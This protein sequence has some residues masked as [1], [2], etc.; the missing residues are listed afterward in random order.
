MTLHPHSAQAPAPQ[1]PQSPQD[2]RNHSFAIRRRGYD[3]EEVDAYLD[4]LSHQIAE[5]VEQNKREVA[6]LIEQ[7]DS[8][9]GAVSD[10]AVVLLG[11]AQQVADSLIN[12]AV[13]S[14]RDLM[15]NARGQQRDIMDQARRAADDVALQVDDLGG[16][17]F[18]VPEVEYVRTYARVAQTQLRAVLEAL[19]EQIEKLGEVPAPPARDR[20]T[21]TA[22]QAWSASRSDDLL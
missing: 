8:A 14:A 10:K 16:P 18:S 11:Q 4:R 13:E 22:D 9:A 20:S 12:E 7:R 21:P 2:I 15:M 5:Q 19:G 1:S 17:Q 6:S 3:E